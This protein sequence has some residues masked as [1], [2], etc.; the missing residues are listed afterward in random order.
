MAQAT[1]VRG[2]PEFRP[3]TPSSAVDAGDVLIIGGRV[4]IAHSPIAAGQRGN[5]AV[6]GGVYRV[7]AGVAI[8]VGLTGLEWDASAGKVVTATNGDADMGSNGLEIA[9]AADG[10]EIEIEH[11]GN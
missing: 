4:C 8:A 5:L 10:D 2:N 11:I 6:G 7:T 9:A 3:Y 1:F